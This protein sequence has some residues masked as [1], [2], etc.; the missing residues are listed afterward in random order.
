[1]RESFAR[2]FG[3][4][5]P[6]LVLGLG[7]VAFCL[8][9]PQIDENRRTFHDLAQL[10]MEH[11]RLA[12]Q[13]RVNTLFLQRV[14]SDPTLTARLAQRQLRVGPGGDEV[15]TLEIAGMRPEPR[16]PFQLVATARPADSGEYRVLGGAL[17][18]PLRNDRTRL[19]VMAGALLLVAAALILD[20]P[21]RRETLRSE[22]ER[23]VVEAVAVES[24]AE[25]TVAD[26]VA[27]HDAN[28]VSANDADVV[29]DSDEVR[30]AA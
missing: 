6:A 15:G 13:M 11:A 25:V 20:G 5:L 26:A 1:M 2:K 29:A 12:E 21:W 9:L 17:L 4:T 3:W 8:M 22:T 10:R 24:A 30:M 23:E 19:Y 16:S 27:E 7:V 28:A 18:D 14:E